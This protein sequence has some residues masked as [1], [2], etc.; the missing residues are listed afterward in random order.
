MDYSTE[1]T[2]FW[3]KVKAG[4]CWHAFSANDKLLGFVRW[5]FDGWDGYVVTGAKWP[6]A[7]RMIRSGPY[8]SRLFWP[9]RRAVNSAIND[10]RN[11][12]GVDPANDPLT[13]NQSPVEAKP[14]GANEKEV[15][16]E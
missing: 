15:T 12:G 13:A 2:I 6:N 11:I 10:L 1:G 7:E 16:H 4:H 8:R 3:R 9:M 14:G 5:N